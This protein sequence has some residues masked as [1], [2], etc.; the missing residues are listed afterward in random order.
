MSARIWSSVQPSSL[1][2]SSLCSPWWAGICSDRLPS[3]SLKCHGGAGIVTVPPCRSGTSRV[4]TQFLAH[5]VLLN[6]LMLRSRPVAILASSNCASTAS[7]ESK[8]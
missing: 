7:M 4:V 2:I 6:S 5:S 8:E 3:W 1:R